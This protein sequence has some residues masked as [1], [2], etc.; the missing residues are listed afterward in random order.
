MERSRREH[1][2]QPFFVYLAL[3]SPHAPWLPPPDLRGA[4]AE[5]PRGDLVALADRCVGEVMAALDRL[6]LRDNTLLIVTSDNGPRHGGYNHRSAGK[7]RGHK[8]H[9]WEGGHRIPFIARWPGHTQA[10]TTSD[11]P[12]ELTDLMATCAAI[13]GTELPEGAGPDSYNVLPALLAKKRGRPIR[14]AIVSHSVFGVFAIR[15][16]PWKL[17]VGTETSGGWVHPRGKA[18]TEGEPGQLYNLN[19][20]PYETENRFSQEPR[21]VAHLTRLLEKYKRAGRSTGIEHPAPPTVR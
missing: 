17:I 4:T 6:G 12:I 3:S 8:S 15:Q 10:G 14:Q 21:R 5:G 7:L 11:E 1:P 2:D 19:A 13:V 9:I 16:G 20:D 18:P